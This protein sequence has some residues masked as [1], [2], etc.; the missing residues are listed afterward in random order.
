MLGNIRAS[1]DV[2]KWKL[3]EISEKDD[4]CLLAECFL[5]PEGNYK[6]FCGKNC[7]ARVNGK[8]DYG[9]RMSFIC[10]QK[11]NLPHIDDVYVWWTED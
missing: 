5:T 6:C 1:I 4:N 10:K 2:K 9:N 3:N 8:W 11:A 7:T